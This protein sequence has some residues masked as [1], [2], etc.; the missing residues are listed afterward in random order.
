MRLWCSLVIML[1]TALL[2]GR[3]GLAPGQEELG[4]LVLI[5]TEMGRI[6]VAIDLERAPNTANN[7]LRYVNAGHFTSGQFHRTVTLD[8]QPDNDVLIEVIQASVSPESRESGFAPI[9]LERTSVTGL[10][11]LD[12]TISMARGG[13]DSATSSFFICIDDQPSLDFGGD[14]NPDGQGFAAFGRVTSGMD[15]VRRIQQSPEEGQRLTPPV[16]ILSVMVVGKEGQSKQG[17]S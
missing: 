12:G 14:R 16:R 8:N 13:P 5:D 17:S 15:V 7:F 2:L 4:T 6:E 10:R 9:A 11:H 1:S 3:S